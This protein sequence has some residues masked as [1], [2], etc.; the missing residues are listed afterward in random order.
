V[1]EFYIRSG[2]TADEF[3]KVSPHLTMSGG[4]FSTGLINVNTASTVVL[5]CVPGI[6]Q[7]MAQQLVSTR[8]GQTTPSTTLAWVVPVLGRDVAI[9]AG[10]YLTTQS[11]QVS[12]DVAAVGRNGRGYR[13]MFTVIDASTGAPQIVYRHNMAANGWALGPQALQ[14]SGTTHK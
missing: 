9:Q 13:R 6:T 11:W 12:A 4:N 7:Q 5:A 2:M 1:L 8:Q 10:P 3:A 14:N